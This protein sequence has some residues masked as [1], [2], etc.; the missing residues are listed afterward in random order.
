MAFDQL[1]RLG[2]I[3]PVD[4]DRGG[5]RPDRQ[6]Q[7]HVQCVDVEQREGQEDDVV[8]PL[9]EVGHRGHLVEVRQQV[10]VREHGALRLRGRSRR[11][12]EHRQVVGIDPDLGG[13][14]IGRQRLLQ[15]DGPRRRGRAAD[16]DDRLQIGKVRPDRV[17]VREPGQL[18][19]DHLGPRV[20]QDRG[21]LDRGEHRVQRADHGADPQRSVE[22]RDEFGNVSRD[23]RNA[24]ARPHPER[25]ERR[26]DRVDDVVE[27]LV[28]V[29]PALEPQGGLGRMFL[30]GLAHDVG[31]VEGGRRRLG[32][33]HRTSANSRS[34]DRACV[35]PAHSACVVPFDSSNATSCHPRA[36]R[37]NRTSRQD[38]ISELWQ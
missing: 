18:R 15:R 2:W 33:G 17:K 37:S 36:V 16:G 20:G 5:A 13:L 25:G 26:A 32:V 12:R 7:D 10:P 14:D 38:A 3:E 6:P 29:G 27:L 34:I 1:D 21:E 24:I 4:H 22:R 11:V 19:D 8:G 9:G 23:Q 31:D 35:R 28:R 30:R